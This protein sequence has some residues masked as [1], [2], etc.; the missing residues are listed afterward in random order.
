[1]RAD[2]AV[3][4]FGG[5]H[6]DV[7][8]VVRSGAIVVSAACGPSVRSAASLFGPGDAFGFD[9]VMSA[10]FPAWGPPP[11]RL[12]RGLVSSRVL[13]IPV[14]AACAAIVERPAVAATLV[15]MLAAQ[16]ERTERRLIRALTLPLVDRL[17]AE[18]QEL[19]AAFGRPVPRGCRIELPLTQD[20]I[21]DLIGAVRESVNRGLRTLVARGLLA[22][23]ASSYVVLDP[24]GS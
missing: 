14:R 20:L 18:L 21:A 4:A 8:G 23:A 16:G 13:L 7:A 2:A 17:L 5:S 9:A 22:R 19:A 10:G 12:A 11:L 15:E 1:M 6:G 3:E 24:P